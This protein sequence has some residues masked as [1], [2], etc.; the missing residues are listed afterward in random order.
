MENKTRHIEGNIFIGP[1][2]DVERLVRDSEQGS[3]LL[4]P[5]SKLDAIH[6]ERA[7]C[8]P[9]IVTAVSGYDSEADKAEALLHQRCRL[10]LVLCRIGLAITEEG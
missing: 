2:N 9:G 6:P 7:L 3:D 5:Y 4:F 1:G 8:C 10:L